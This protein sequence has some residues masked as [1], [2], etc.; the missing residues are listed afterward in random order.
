MGILH[1]NSNYSHQGYKP[2]GSVFINKTL[3]KCTSLIICLSLCYVFPL[4]RWDGSYQSAPI[5]RTIRSVYFK[6]GDF[7]FLSV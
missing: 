1:V 5:C 3:Q 7:F 4:N 2:S 6:I